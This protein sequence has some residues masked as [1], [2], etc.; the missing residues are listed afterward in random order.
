MLRTPGTQEGDLDWLGGE[1]IMERQVRHMSRLIDDLLDVS[2]G[3]TR[4]RS[5][6]GGNASISI[7]SRPPAV[8]AARSAIEARSHRLE[9]RAA[10]GSDCADA[11]PTRLEQVLVNLLKNA[12]KYTEPGGRIHSCPA[13]EGPA[14][15]RVRD[16]GVGI[17]AETLTTVFD[18]FSQADSL[19]GPLP[20][21]PRDRPD[22]GQ[23]WSSCTAA[24]VTPA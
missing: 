10:I 13:G 6:C 1:E 15:V 20:G 4:G 23:R 14:I 8:E 19:A 18:L 3:A 9:G 7:G 17:A 21:G 2:R 5:R 16:T 11:D 12:A 22:P 24:R